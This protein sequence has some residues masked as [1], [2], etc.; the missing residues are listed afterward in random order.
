MFYG[1]WRRVER[2][3]G[4]QGAFDSELVQSLVS[5]LTL[6]LNDSRLFYA[7]YVTIVVL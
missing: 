7:Y 4:F 3:A 5:L 2:Q 1:L 6:E